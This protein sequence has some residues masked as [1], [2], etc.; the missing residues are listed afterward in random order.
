MCGSLQVAVPTL[1]VPQSPAC[2]PVLAFNS[3]LSLHLSSPH[4][5]F[6][7]S[8]SDRSSDENRAFSGEESQN[9]GW[10]CPKQDAEVPEPYH[11][12]G[13][14]QVGVSLGSWAGE[15]RKGARGP[16]SGPSHTEGSQCVKHP[17]ILGG[18]AVSCSCCSGP[19]WG[20]C[21]L[22]FSQPV[23]PPPHP[24]VSAARCPDVTRELL[25]DPCGKP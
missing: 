11:P 1:P 20:L 14:G 25:A 21:G 13:G 23:P 8:W 19:V 4:L 22:E 10:E 17:T 7:L 24:L 5:N 16:E 9:W 6:L 3:L 18:A 15:E 12:L 2:Q